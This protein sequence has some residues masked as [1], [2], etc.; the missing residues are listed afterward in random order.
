MSGKT[1]LSNEKL[2]KLKDYIEVKKQID[3]QKS[4][5]LEQLSQAEELYYKNTNGKE[6]GCT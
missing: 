1:N 4:W 3:S 5:H 2:E 6:V